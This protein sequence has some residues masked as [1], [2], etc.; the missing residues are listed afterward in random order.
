[1]TRTTEA[2]RSGNESKK[3]RIEDI[4]KI[5]IV[6]IADIPDTGL[7]TERI[8]SR[9]LSTGRRNRLRWDKEKQPEVSEGRVFAEGVSNSLY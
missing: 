8:L 6:S 9:L 3:R 4:K 1:M 5:P 2:P 7:K